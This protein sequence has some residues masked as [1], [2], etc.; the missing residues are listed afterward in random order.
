MTS[1]PPAGSQ[2]PPTGPAPAGIERELSP[3][4]AGY[5]FPPPPPD[6]SGW[7]RLHPLSAVVRAGPGAVAVLLLVLF[8]S[9]GPGS[10]GRT[11]DLL[12]AGLLALFLLAGFVSWAVTRWQLT[13]G[14]LQIETGLIRRRSLRFPLSQVQ[15]IDVVRPGLARLL[16]LAELRIR[17]AGAGSRGRLAYLTVAHAEALRARL[18]ATA[19]SAPALDGEPP[20]PPETPLYSIDPRRLLGSLLISGPSMFLLL[21]LLALAVLAAVAPGAARGLAAGSLAYLLGLATTLWRRFNGEYRLS[22]AEAVDGLHLRAGLVETSAETI[23]RGRIQALRLV[24]PLTWR[25]LGWWRVEV[26]VAGKAA[27]G[28]NDRAA[29]QAAR[30]LLPV[31]TRE[32]AAWIVERVFPGATA[33]LTPPPPRVVWKAPL[34]YRH[35]AAGLDS[36]YAVTTSGRLRRATDWVPLAKVQSIRWVQGPVQRRMRLA[37]IHLDTA[38]RG[39][40]AVLR[41]RERS[42]ADAWLAWLPGACQRDR[43]TDPAATLRRAMGAGRRCAGGSCGPAGERR[44]V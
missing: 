38:G 10:G 11:T 15:A 42:Q 20:P 34:R 23:P 26:D 1:P 24:Q 33:A 18:L 36:S 44:P 2:S 37:S 4:Q 40:F 35:L 19:H 30:A 32:Q 8:S 27:A 12:D 21:C 6:L 14:V 13:E 43:A 41:D 31:G 29:K 5:G 22:V 7:R 39:V 28:R 16:G 17:V 9:G 3:R 25:P